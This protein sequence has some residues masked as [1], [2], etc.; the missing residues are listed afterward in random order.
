MNC[1]YHP[2]DRYAVTQ[3]GRCGKGLC[4]DCAYGEGSDVRCF[5]DV[6]A[7]IQVDYKIAKNRTIRLWVFTVLA[8]LALIVPLLLTVNEQLSY[9]SPGASLTLRAILEPILLCLV[10][11]PSAWFF[12]MGMS[13]IYEKVRG[14][15][16]GVG[17]GV[18][19]VSRGTPANLETATGSLL[20]MVFVV[21]IILVLIA[22]L[23]WP[24]IIIGLFTGIQKYRMDRKIVRIIDSGEW[25]E[26]FPGK[27]RPDTQEYI[28][29]PGSPEPE[30]E[31]V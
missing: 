12:Y 17:V 5:D 31:P 19:F 2:A 25:V 23:A 16:S 22:F 1:F 4:A 8:S 6:L 7:A 18:G 21:G 24:V 26:W 10:I 15:G 28:P 9:V 20:G 11:P 3:C 30:P 29:V 27:Y 13:W 14:R